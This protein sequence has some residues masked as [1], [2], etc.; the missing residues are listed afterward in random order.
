MNRSQ[1]THHRNLL[2]YK[3]AAQLRGEQRKIKR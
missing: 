2:Q 1:E 3:Y